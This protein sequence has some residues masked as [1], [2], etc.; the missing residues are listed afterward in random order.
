MHC[1]TNF[2]A[3]VSRNYITYIT[4]IWLL[5]HNYKFNQEAKLGMPFSWD[6]LKLN[7]HLVQTQLS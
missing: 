1:A 3:E 2:N 6:M 7:L 5:L 4:P